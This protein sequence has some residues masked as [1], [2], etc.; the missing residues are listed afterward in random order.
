MGFRGYN[1]TR[2]SKCDNKEVAN[3]SKNRYNKRLLITL[4]I[5][6]KNYKL[7]ST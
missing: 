4:T 5:L 3:N 1:N 2:E 6:T 7:N